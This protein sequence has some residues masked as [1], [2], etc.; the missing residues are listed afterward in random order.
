[1]N[2][3]KSKSSGE[4]ESIKPESS[5]LRVL[6]PRLGGL[7]KPSRRKKTLK[8]V[9]KKRVRKNLPVSESLDT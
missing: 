5:P 6:I 9:K 4:L 3:L 8:I 1:M 7:P 2:L